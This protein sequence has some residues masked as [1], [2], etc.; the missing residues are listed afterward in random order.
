MKDI[1]FLLYIVT[2]LISV[3]SIFSSILLYFYKK[4]T[5]LKYFIHLLLVFLLI[6]TVYTTFY[7]IFLYTYKVTA[8]LDRILLIMFIYI[9][10]YML[11]SSLFL[12][13]AIKEITITNKI[14][15]VI[16]AIMFCYLF[17]STFIVVIEN[18]I[19]IN[20]FLILIDLSIIVLLLL[21][22]IKLKNLI[23]N[24]NQN[25]L[26]Y[27]ILL[28]LILA[29]VEIVEFLIRKDNMMHDTYIPMGAI[30]FAFFCLLL[31]VINLILTLPKILHSKGII[32][33]NRDVMFNSLIEQYKI[34]H[35]EKNILLKVQKG[36]NNKEI[37]WELKLSTRTVERHIYNIYK[38][39][40]ISNRIELINLIN[41]KTK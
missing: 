36:L 32:N 33:Q 17:F 15:T 5:W 4:E 6:I 25:I 20:Y 10:S 38:K 24:K 12:G 23:H 14:R 8:V 35:S 29:P 27:L 26:V 40:N 3:L 11:G 39:C 2:L 28:S 13:F 34:S 31:N 19:F 37:A 9:F 18:K 1:I 41:S 7:F 21:S 22:L 30:T 16:Y